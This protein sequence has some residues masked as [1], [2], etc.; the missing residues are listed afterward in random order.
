MENVFRNLSLTTYFFGHL[1]TMIILSIFWDATT[2]RENSQ[3]CDTGIFYFALFSPF[4]FNFF[5]PIL[6]YFI[7][8]D[9]WGEVKKMQIGFCLTHLILGIL[10]MSVLL[11]LEERD[12]ERI[13]I[14]ENLNKKVKESISSDQ[15]DHK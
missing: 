15:E 7:C 4:T 2:L 6:P 12:F 10:V 14:A 5:N 11:W 8:E 3:K 1:F 13:F 9:L